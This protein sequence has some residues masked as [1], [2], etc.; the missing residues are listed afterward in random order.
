MKFRN[1]LFKILLVLV[2]IID[3]VA[4]ASIAQWREDQATNIWLGLTRPIIQIPVGLMSSYNIPNPNGM[5]L[6]GKLLSFLPNLWAV[7][8]FLGC[9]QALVIVLIALKFVNSNDNKTQKYFWIILLPLLT[10]VLL[11]ARSVEFW[12]HDMILLVNLIF[13]WWGVSY[14]Q[15]PSLVKM[16]FLLGLVLLVPA[17]YLA[18]IVNAIVMFVLGS[19]LVLYRPPENWK[20]DW[21]KP[22]LLGLL[23]CGIIFILVWLPY[24]TVMMQDNLL[25]SSPVGSLS[26][27]GRIYFAADA[28]LRLPLWIFN[29]WQYQ[30]T[31]FFIPRSGAMLSGLGIQLIQ[32]IPY[33]HLAQTMLALGVAVYALTYYW[34]HRGE[35]QTLIA[36][37][38]HL[39]LLFVVLAFTFV[40]LSYIFSPLLG[41]S[42]WARNERPDQTVA[43]HPFFMVVWV[44]LPHIFVVPDKIKKWVI[45]LSMLGVVV[46]SIVNVVAGVMIIQAHLKYHGDI[47]TG[48]DV[49]LVQIEQ[50]VDFM[51]QDW[52]SISDEQVIPVDY[53]LG[54]EIWD[55][56][57]QFGKSLEP[58]YPAPY[59]FG[60]A[61]DYELL[62]R[63]DLY[64]LQEGVQTRTFGEGRY[65]VNYSFDPP[66]EVDGDLVEAHLFGRI[67]V[68]VVNR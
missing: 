19:L 33:I 30:S 57:P 29:Q 52:Y 64:N 39:I 63:Y 6:L 23:I 54:G 41:G 25:T 7:S 10:S 18:G 60:R 65:L 45:G 40:L 11:R 66:P 27:K 22:A 56:T 49:P 38:S 67:R 42:I 20:P 16:P 26:L 5:L 61:Y 58:W 47:H 37:E 15:K 68:T 12:N 4:W 28:V 9:L 62:R 34:K 59:T 51:A 46:F 48:A 53:Q 13:L 8:I 14:Y 35:T 17:I 3:R 21:W 44:L 31:H 50:A 1:S 55:W 24:A 32:S 43:F 2:V 36:E